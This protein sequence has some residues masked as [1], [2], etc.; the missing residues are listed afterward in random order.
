MLNV[1]TVDVEDWFQ[2][3]A[4][5][6]EYPV[7]KWDAQRP[8]ILGNIIKTLQ[9]LDEYDTKATFFV[10]GWIAEKFPEVVKSIHERGHEIASHSQYHRL[11]SSLDRAEFKTDLQQS[12]LNIER[13]VDVTVKGYRAP[14]FS[15]CPEDKWV[16]EVFAECG[17]E[18]DSSVFPIRHDTYGTP[19]APRFA[20]RVKSTENISVLEIPPSTVRLFGT[21]IPV[22]GGGYLR[23]FPYWLIQRSIRRING[24]GY[25]A[26]VYFH[27][28]EL[29]SDQKRVTASLKSRFRHYTNLRAFEMKLRR[30]LADFRFSSIS[31]V[32]I[33]NVS[34]VVD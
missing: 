12:I 10:L 23:M 19:S 13:C 33:R 32:F 5:S 15:I 31:E 21:N 20:Y 16:W 30:L 22:G 6:N 3:Q 17:V 9:L 4:F 14:S 34:G 18:Y 27:P 8:R 28:W 29:D 1:L 25:P 24:E 7:S 26:V 2:V 11:V